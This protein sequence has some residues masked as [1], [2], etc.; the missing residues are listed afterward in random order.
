MS[1]GPGPV[2]Q[3]ILALIKSDKDGAW[4]LG[5]VC[6]HVYGAV[7]DSLP[8]SFVVVGC[9]EAWQDRPEG[10]EPYMVFLGKQQV[11][12]AR[13]DGE[14]VATGLLG[15]PDKL[16]SFPGRYH[17]D[18]EPVWRVLGEQQHPRRSYG[19]VP[20]GPGTEPGMNVPLSAFL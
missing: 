17:V 8:H 20:V 19:F 15:F 3:A 16:D 2:Q 1:R 4:P 10:P 9:L 11:L 7:E 6:Q 13:L 5:Q 18:V 12:G 14:L